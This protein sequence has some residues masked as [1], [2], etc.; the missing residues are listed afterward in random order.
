MSGKIGFWSVFALVTGSQIGSSV[1]MAP[2]NLANYG[3]LAVWG[4]VIAALGAMALCYVFAVLCGRYPKTG[5]PHVYINNL[6]GKTPAFFTG[7]TYWII[8]WI[9]TTAVIVTAIGYLAPFLGIDDKMT[10][11]AFE[12]GL[13]LIIT[14]INLQGVK[15]AGNA[16]FFLTILKL[17]PLII[18]P[19][20]ALFFFKAEHFV[21]A[22]HLTQ[23]FSMSQ[24]LGQVTLVTLWGFIGLETAT[25][26]AESVENPTKN[27][28][29]ALILGTLCVALVY[30]INCVG[31]M[32][33][34]APE[35][36]KNSKA[37]YV[38]AAQVLFGGQWHLLISVVASVVCI[39]TL[40]AWI[41]TSGQIA[42][43]LAQD[44]LMPAFFAK[45]NGKDAPYWSILISSL[46]IVP[47]LVM[48][49][50]DNFADQIRSIIDISVTSFLFVYLM[51]C[52]G[53]L[54]LTYE[55]GRKG[56]LCLGLVALVFCSW[57]IYETPLRVL[58]MSSFFTI[59]G[60]PLYLF[61]YLKKKRSSAL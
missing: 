47:F 53:F 51:C 11:L 27:I 49:I 48:T 5:G 8:S 44:G 42:L 34:V 45:K 16:E 21:V 20:G 54:K 37:P 18:L 31:V 1:F 29:R 9:S 15:I 7:W 60:I 32:G 19:I 30:I 38:D 39:G 35:V 25:T 17:L 52:G 26:P 57:I 56:A 23:E 22:Q 41:L 61:W 24:L 43:G 6:F 36:L 4:F 13:L 55:Q 14:L 2:A 40:N 10:F 59:S 12:I 33:L 3:W 50:E 46:G 28:P 58:A